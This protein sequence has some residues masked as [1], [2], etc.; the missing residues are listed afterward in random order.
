METKQWQCV[1]CGKT[2]HEVA[3]IEFHFAGATGGI[4]TSCL[5]TLI[6]HPEKLADKLPRTPRP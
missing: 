5:P 2:E 1:N 4:C 3:V 6:H